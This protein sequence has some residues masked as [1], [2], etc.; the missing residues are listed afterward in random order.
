MNKNLL[1]DLKNIR[2]KYN[3]TL[4][5]DIINQVSRQVIQD[6]CPHM[7]QKTEKGSCFYGDF[8]ITKCRTCGKTLNHVRHW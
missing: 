1:T 8:E 2:Q 4:L 7:Q 3:F 6:E 5:N